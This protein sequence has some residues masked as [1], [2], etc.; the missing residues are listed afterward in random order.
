MS[1][2]KFEYVTKIVGRDVR[3]QVRWIMDNVE[4][5][6]IDKFQ[7]YPPPPPPDPNPA[8]WL[9]G[10][11]GGYFGEPMSVTFFDQ[12]DAAKF[13]MFFSDDD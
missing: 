2:M 13:K 4:R 10:G 3:E 5:F 11:T 12:A 1:G 7:G 6:K 8:A 9:L